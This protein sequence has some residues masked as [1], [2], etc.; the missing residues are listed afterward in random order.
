MSDNLELVFLL[1]L[2]TSFL[3]VYIENVRLKLKYE[4]KVKIDPQ[5]KILF[6][7]LQKQYLY[8]CTDSDIKQLIYFLNNY[9]EER[10][11]KK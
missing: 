8:Q 10:K 1:I 3:L 4:F 11:L 6:Y 9:L 2:F 5:N 7:K